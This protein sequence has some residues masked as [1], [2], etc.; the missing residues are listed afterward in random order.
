M[1]IVG[2]L[3]KTQV[4]LSDAR[5]AGAIASGSIG[6]SYANVVGWLNGNVGLIASLLGIVLTLVTIRVQWT[7]GKKAELELR[8]L[9]KEMAECDCTD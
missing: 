5:A 2:L 1:S 8:R 9:Q 4:I 6:V 7:N 3:G